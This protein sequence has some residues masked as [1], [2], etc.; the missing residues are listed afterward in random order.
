MEKHSSWELEKKV[1]EKKEKQE[2]NQREFKFI[3]LEL[4]IEHSGDLEILKWGA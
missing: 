2:E 4:R 1:R 3:I